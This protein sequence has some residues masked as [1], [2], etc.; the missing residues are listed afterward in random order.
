MAIQPVRGKVYTLREII[1][2]LPF[3][4]GPAHF[5]LTLLVL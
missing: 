5:A 3:R 1:L 2:D 4:Y